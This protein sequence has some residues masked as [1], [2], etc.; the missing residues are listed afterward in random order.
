MFDN[1]ASVRFAKDTSKPGPVNIEVA[2]MISSEGEVMDF[3]DA[4]PVRGSV[5]QWMT[6]VEAEM[7]RTNRLITKEA[8]FYYRSSMSRY[9]SPCLI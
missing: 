4:Q 2:A 7:K 1:I 9:V 6:A 3:R 5:E 8:V